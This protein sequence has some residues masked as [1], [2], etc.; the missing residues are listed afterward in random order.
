[1]FPVFE[2]LVI[3]ATQSNSSEL[4]S[5]PSITYYSL[6]LF[7][8]LMRS[9]FSYLIYSYYKR[10]ERGEQL[11][12]DYGDRK[13]SRMIEEIKEEQRKQEWELELTERASSRV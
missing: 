13:L 1:M 12:V 6:I 9:Y 4:T 7:K 8:A 3:F 10:V 11:L 5:S 2:L